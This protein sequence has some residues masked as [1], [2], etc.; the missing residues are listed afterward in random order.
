M[1]ILKYSDYDND[2]FSGILYLNFFRTISELEIC[3]FLSSSANFLS[4]LSIELSRSLENPISVEF[5]LPILLDAYTY[6]GLSH[7]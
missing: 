2:K 6:T 3:G 5:H 1:G 4:L 7:N